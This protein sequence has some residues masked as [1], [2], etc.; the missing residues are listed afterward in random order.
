G[1]IAALRRHLATT[2]PEM[3]EAEIERVARQ[4][5][6]EVETRTPS[7]QTWQYF[8][9]PAHCGDYCRY[10]KEVG[11]P[12]L[13][14]LAADGDGPAYLAAHASDISDIEHAREVWEGIRPDAPTDISQAYSVGVYLFTCLVCGEHVLLWDCD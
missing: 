2:H 13:L 14:A 10:I 12:E 9:W 4:R 3:S 7:P 6:I 1:D 11:Q 5:T 8:D